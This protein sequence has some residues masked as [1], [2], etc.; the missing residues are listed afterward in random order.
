MGWGAA[1]AGLLKLLVAL[2]QYLGNKQLLDA[3]AAKAIAE[4]ANDTLARI[5]AARDAA[6]AIEHPATRAD[7][8]WADR[9][10]DRF[11]NPKH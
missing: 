3:G 2:A 9:V 5:A 1:L 11:G 4:G 10:R 7:A 8:D 6:A